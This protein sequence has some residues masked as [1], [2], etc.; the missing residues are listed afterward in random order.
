MREMDPSEEIEF[1]RAMMTDEN[2]LIEVESL[3]RTYQKLGKL[4]EQEPPKELVEQISAMAVENQQKK[5]HS[6]NGRFLFLAKSV[7]VAAAVLMLVSTGVY[8]INQSGSVLPTKPA[9][10]AVETNTAPISPWVDR[11]EIIQFTGTA[12]QPANSQSL[13]KDVT[14]SFGKLRLVNE[15]TGIAPPARKIVLTSTSR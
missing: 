13:Q 10:A 14:E 7:A 3:R 9:E 15:N 8:Y 6:S 4:P 12:L 2:L 1:E 5:L 11:N